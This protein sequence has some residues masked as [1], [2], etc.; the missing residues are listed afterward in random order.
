MEQLEEVILTLTERNLV[1][2]KGKDRKESFCFV[3]IPADA[4]ETVHETNTN[5]DDSN[6]N[7]LKDCIGDKFY[8]ILVNK[9]KVEIK[10][11]SF[12]L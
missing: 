5:R 2:N 12:F 6:F 8:T 3:E 11:A 4:E 9:I 1:V 7:A 10:I